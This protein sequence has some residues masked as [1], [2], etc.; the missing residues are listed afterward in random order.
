[1]V[2]RTFIRES[3]R[4]GAFWNN[5]EFGFPPRRGKIAKGAAPD[6]QVHM[7]LSGVIAGKFHKLMSSINSMRRLGPNYRTRQ[8][9]AGIPL[10]GQE[11][12]TCQL[13]NH[14]V[15]ACPEFGFTACANRAGGLTG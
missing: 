15:G 4:D 7:A 5:R 8:L 6:F 13:L 9:T 12:T 3:K 11:L 2:R 1:L 14:I 10:S